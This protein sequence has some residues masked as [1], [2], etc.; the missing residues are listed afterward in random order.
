M[1]VP[2][3]SSNLFRAPNFS[4]WKNIFRKNMFRSFPSGTPFADRIAT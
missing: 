1:V 4:R 3:F 2:D